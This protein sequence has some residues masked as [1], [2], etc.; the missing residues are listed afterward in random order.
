MKIS[1]F[2]PSENI[3]NQWLSNRHQEAFSYSEVGATKADFP[4]GYNHDRNKCLLGT[5]DEVFEKAKKAL[6]NWQHFPANWT[7]IYPNNGF[8]VNEEV[9]VLF[10]LFGLYWFNSCRVI[11]IIDEDNRFGFAYG[12][13][14]NHVE[15]GEEI[16]FLERDDTGKVWYKIQAFSQPRFWMARIGKPI[17][18]AFQRKFVKNSFEA[19]QHAVK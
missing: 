19:M 12:T 7:K 14:K 3:L 6:Q 8:K 17:T 1:I 11:Y 2:K 10:H 18:R 9:V 4:K 16:F 5:G 15:K 13:L